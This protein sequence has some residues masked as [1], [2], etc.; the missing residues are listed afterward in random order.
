MF[1]K[2]FYGKDG[3]SLNEY[4][5]SISACILGLSV[6]IHSGW[7]SPFIPKLTKA[8]GYPFN[9]TSEDASYIA[10]LGPA[11]DLIG[12]V[13][14]MSVVDIIGRKT[15]LMI[16]GIPIFLS[17]MLIYFS[18]ISPLCIYIAR[19]LG[20]ISM[21][22]FMSIA[23]MYISE[24]SSP[25]IRG[26]L[27]I[28]VVFSGTSAL[29]IVNLA[30]KFLDVYI[31]SLIFAAIVLSF[32]LLF[33]MM[34][35]SPYYF[36]MKGNLE[37]AE[38][39]LRFLRRTESVQ[40]ELGSLEEDVK[41]QLSE[42]GTLKDLFSINSN[43]KALFLMICGRFIQQLT[44]FFAFVMYGRSLLTDSEEIID[45]ETAI[46]IIS[47]IQSCFG[48]LSGSLADKFGRV[49][50]MAFST[51]VC[52]VTLTLFGLYFT[53]RD[54]TTL[55]VPIWLPLVIYAV[56]F[57]SIQLG[58]GSLLTVMLGELFSA[59]IKP[60]AVCFV[61]ITFSL[62]VMLTAKFYQVCTDYLHT[63]VCFYVF[64]VVTLAGTIFIKCYYPE[65]KGK[66]LEEIQLE[67]KGIQREKN[68]T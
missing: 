62:S 29:I 40:K 59:S 5:T 13:T 2:Y 22:M 42:N 39:S 23:P 3:S 31:S 28:L 30:G 57:F 36:L 24:I 41:R 7:T 44:G 53:L 21:G 26:K 32:L 38:K 27:G 68:V 17:N 50:L 64:A 20:G 43:R 56:H 12:E 34:P 14:S 67:L 58:V 8:G 52:F 51:A 35:E 33:S 10:I 66:T 16:F 9:V 60:K 54:F 46:I 49:P 47:A 63:S 19:L 4:L 65:T 61:N 48:I 1:F 18:Y 37:G 25:A 11:G 55:S 6:G 15:S 45:P